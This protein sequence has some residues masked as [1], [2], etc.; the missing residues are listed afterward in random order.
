MGQL[1]GKRILTFGDSIIAGH[2]YE[3][4]GFVE[5]AAA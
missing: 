5:F 1:A 4:A 2:L 3:Q